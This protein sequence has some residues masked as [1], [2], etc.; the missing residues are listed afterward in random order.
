[1]V[2]YVNAIQTPT[3]VVVDPAVFPVI[4]S[5]MA[6]LLLEMLLVSTALLIFIPLK[7]LLLLVWLPALIMLL[8]SI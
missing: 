4:L 7:A 8:T 1:M 6:A 2:V 5:A 3:R